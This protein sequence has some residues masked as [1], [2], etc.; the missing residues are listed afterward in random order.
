MILRDKV[1]SELLKVGQIHEYHALVELVIESLS[2]DARG[3]IVEIGNVLIISRQAYIFCL[4]RASIIFTHLFHLLFN[5]LVLILMQ[6][7]GNF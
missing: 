5:R 2:L 1:A 3:H 7:T 4:R 6:I